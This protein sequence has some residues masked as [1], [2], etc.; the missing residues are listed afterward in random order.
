MRVRMYCLGLLSV[1]CLAP[2]A[3]GE[4]WP[5]FR[6][7]NGS[8]VSAEV[9]LPVTWSD[10]ENVAWKVDLPGPGSSSPI[11]SG[12]RV[13]VTCY[14]GYGA[15]A[16]GPG[17]PEKLTRHVVCLQLR[18]G[19]VLW[20]EAIPARQPEDPYQGQLTTHGY[21][22]ST[23]AA[24]GQSVFVACGKS[25]VFAFDGDG[26]QRWQ[27]S[28]GT[29]SAIMGWGSATSL[30]VYKNLVIVNANAE[31]ES[32]VALDKETGREVWKAPA[33]GYAG[34]FSTPILVD[35]AGRQELAVRMPDEVW[36]L[37]PDRG[38]LLWYCSGVR[39]AAVPSLVAENGLVYAVGGGPQ[40]AGSIAIRAGGRGDVSAS[41]VV[42]RQPTG[43]YVPSPVLVNGHV[44]WVDDRG[45]AYCL[46][47][48]TGQQVY[49]ERL[50]EAGSVYA[51]AIA[52]DGKL[53]VVTRRNGT[54]VLA[55]G[56]EFKV[57]AHNRLSADSTDFNA[58]PAI[59][60]G[61]LLLRSNRGLYCVCGK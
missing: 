35:S 10:T 11:V 23:P 38:G 56:S 26:K 24:D 50:P 46:R 51:S 9:R 12:D 37:D 25:G 32:L 14:S 54:F 31:S 19:K 16:W 61:R 17:D 28:V 29:G 58:S 43:S 15:E 42:W 34:S 3:G 21:A 1:A 53:Y 7:P 39:G 5:R 4:D 2:R 59:S 8:G 13:F 45:T 27:K 49:R 40:G 47:A 33:E 44:H 6:G 55:A 20:Q 30:L 41:H 60:D 36:G 52:A 57:L 48:D 18:D 22:S